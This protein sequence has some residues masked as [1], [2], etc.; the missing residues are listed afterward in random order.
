MQHHTIGKI[1]GKIASLAN[2]SAKEIKVFE[3]IFSFTF[4]NTELEFDEASIEIFTSV[5]GLKTSG[6]APERLLEDELL[7]AAPIGR[8]GAAFGVGRA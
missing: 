4:Y 3:Y 2:N 1:G 7:L 6:C 5:F 8:G